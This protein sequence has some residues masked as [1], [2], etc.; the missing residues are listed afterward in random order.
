M[1]NIPLCLKGKNKQKE[2]SADHGSSTCV[3]DWRHIV[4]KQIVNICLDLLFSRIQML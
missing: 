2:I 1:Y 4:K 3:T